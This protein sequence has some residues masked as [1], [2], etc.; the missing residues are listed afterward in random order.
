[1][2]KVRKRRTNNEARYCVY[3]IDE[4]RYSR[5]MTLSQAKALVVQFETAYIVNAETA[6]VIF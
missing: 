1:M 4:G 5:L 2:E 6:E 3:Y